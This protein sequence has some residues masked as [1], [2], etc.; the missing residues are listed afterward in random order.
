MAFQLDWTMGLD[1]VYVLLVGS[2]ELSFTAGMV[3]KRSRIGA[4]HGAR[5][6]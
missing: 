6:R 3:G 4:R 2:G 5:P 1:K